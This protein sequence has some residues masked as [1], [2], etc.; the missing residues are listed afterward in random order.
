MAGPAAV[1]P[2]DDFLCVI[3]ICFGTTPNSPLLKPSSAECFYWG[4]E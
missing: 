2:P 4:V 1:M 3:H